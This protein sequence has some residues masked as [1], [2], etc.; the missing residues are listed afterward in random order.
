MGMERP[1]DVARASLVRVGEYSRQHQQER[2]GRAQS[3]SSAA[4]EQGSSAAAEQEEYVMPTAQRDWA[5]T[6][7]GAEH[8]ALH[9]FTVGHLMPRTGEGW[10]EQQQGQ[11]QSRS[12][13]GSQSQSRSQ[14]QAQGR[15]GFGEGE[16]SQQQAGTSAVATTSNA[17]STLRVRRSAFVPGWAVPPRVLLVDDDAVSRKLGSKF[18]QVFGCTIDMA[19]DGVS[20]VHKMNLEKYD[21]VLM[22]RVAFVL[23]FFSEA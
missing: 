22:V 16:S 4:G 20:A 1:E 5:P 17:Q 23:S 14:A 6:G 12:R 11:S 10:Y 21:L 9:V 15:Y 8:E 3:Q 13:S 18:L 2:R 7:S 19:V